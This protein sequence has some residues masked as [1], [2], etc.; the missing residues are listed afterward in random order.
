VI[1]KATT[2]GLLSDPLKLFRLLDALSKAV[3]VDETLT[4]AGMDALGLQMR[5]LRTANTAVRR[6][7]VR[8]IGR[9]VRLPRT[10]AASAELWVA[11]RDGT[12]DGYLRR[13]PGDTVKAPR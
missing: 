1:D 7:P 2:G 13:Y 8:G 9:G 4:S 3:S 12:V 5:G 6:G 11:V 10:T